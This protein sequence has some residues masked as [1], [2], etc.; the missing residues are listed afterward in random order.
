MGS[1]NLNL[2]VPQGQFGTRLTG[3]KDAASP[4]YIFTYLS[5]IA[6]YLFPEED[7]VLLRYLEDDGQSIEPEF[8][9]PIIPML[10]IN[11]SQGIGTGWSTQIPSY[12]P[13]DVLLYILAKLDR[14]EELPPIRPYARGFTGNIKPSDDG[15]GFVSHGRAQQ[16]S[17][18]S[19]VIDELP[20]KCWTDQYKQRLLKMRN[21]AEIINF[22][23]DHTTTKVSFKV[24]M[25]SVKLKRLLKNAGGLETAFKLKANIS[26]SNMNAFDADGS[27]RKFDSPEEIADIYFPVRLALY[28]DRKSMLQSEM[29]HASVLMRSKADFVQAVVSGDI[30]L[31]S[32]KQSKAEI[33]EQLRRL[34]LTSAYD[35]DEIRNNNTVYKKRQ[36]EAETSPG[37]EVH[38]TEVS[39]SGE[40]DYLLNMPLSSLT[41][42]KISQLKEDAQ[43]KESALE[44]IEKK[45]PA[46]L[47]R[48]DLEKLAPLI[49]KLKA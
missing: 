25:K 3:G 27:I 47:W 40:Y 29:K 38:E 18:T 14:L 2:L 10:L 36:S 42:E 49:R 39:R 17:A 31:V 33:T 34:G 12:D 4:R 20:L 37:G 15:R 32:G 7:D 41:S 11:G 8:Y 9:C 21:R 48:D 45:S 22:V 16:T 44:E 6:R 43:N 46:D 24:N 35:L 30:D 19:L 13:E 5:N 26:T 1:N 23:E 28:H